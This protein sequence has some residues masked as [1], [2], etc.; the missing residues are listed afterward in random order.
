[1]AIIVQHR[2][3]GQRF[4]LLGTGYA[5]WLATTPGL[6]L[7]NLSPNRE[8]GEKAVIAV[9]DNEGNISWWEPELLQVIEVDGKRPVEVLGNVNLKA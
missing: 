8:S 3:T 4:V 7:G 9:A 1:M 2:T 6:F 5:Q